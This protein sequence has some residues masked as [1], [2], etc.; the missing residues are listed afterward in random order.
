MEQ[1]LLALKSSIACME[2]IRKSIAKNDQIESAEGLATK[3]NQFSGS[4]GVLF[5]AGRDM[6]QSSLLEIPLDMLSFLDGEI[7]NPELYYYKAIEDAETHAMKLQNRIQ[8]L[9]SIQ[10]HTSKSFGESS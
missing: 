5:E 3:F 4:L 9:Q 7:S 1:K 2:S 8:H 10:E 6:D